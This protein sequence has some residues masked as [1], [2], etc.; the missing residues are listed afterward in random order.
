MTEFWSQRRLKDADS[1]ILMGS[2]ARVSLKR[3]NHSQNTDLCA[4]NS[5]LAVIMQTLIWCANNN[6]TRERNNKT[7]L[8]LIQQNDKHFLAPASLEN[9]QQ[10]YSNSPHNQILH[11]KP[12]PSPVIG[13]FVYLCCVISGRKVHQTRKPPTLWKTCRTRSRGDFPLDI[14]VLNVVFA[15][16]VW[17]L[18]KDPKFPQLVF[19]TSR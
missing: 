2:N 4:V 14:A 3:K 19:W 15:V 8:R 1:L 13:S 6:S 17:Q 10:S 5:S 18:T 7:V 11:L 12:R 9:R 16:V